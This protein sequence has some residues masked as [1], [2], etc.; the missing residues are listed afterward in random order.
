MYW[1]CKC[2]LSHIRVCRPFREIYLDLFDHV[3]GLFVVT[4]ICLL[5]ITVV[6][7][8]GA[9]QSNRLLAFCRGRLMGPSFTI[10]EF[11]VSLPLSQHS[12]ATYNLLDTYFL[13]PL[14]PSVSLRKWA[15]GLNNRLSVFL[16]ISN[17]FRSPLICF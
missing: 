10:R 1:M 8:N 13:R 11:S 3:K 15:L 6:V 5:K 9:V 12:Y 17:H 4:L 14:P 2:A 16:E 7:D